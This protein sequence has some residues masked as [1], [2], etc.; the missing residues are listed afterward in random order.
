MVNSVLLFLFLPLL[1]LPRQRLSSQKGLRI[2]QNLIKTNERASKG[3]THTDPYMLLLERL[4]IAAYHLRHGLNKGRHLSSLVLRPSP[5]PDSQRRPPW[6]SE[7]I[8]C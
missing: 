1:P 2:D 6:C 7:R 3:L 5:Q 8:L 4:S